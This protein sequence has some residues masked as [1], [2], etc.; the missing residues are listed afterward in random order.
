ME[1]V[2]NKVSDKAVTGYLSAPKLWQLPRRRYKLTQSR[3][4]GYRNNERPVRGPLSFLLAFPVASSE[5]SG[6]ESNAADP[7]VREHA[8]AEAHCVRG[9]TRVTECVVDFEEQR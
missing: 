1:L 5:I 8:Q 7:I 6:S 3:T 2:V 9:S 4:T